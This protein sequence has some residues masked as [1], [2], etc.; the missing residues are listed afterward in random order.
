YLLDCQNVRIKGRGV[1]D[2][3][4]RALR[5]S[6]DNSSNGRMKLIRSLRATDCTVEGVI[7]RD[8]GTWSIHLIESSDLRFTNYKLISNTILDDPGFPWELNTDGFDPDNSSHVII[9]NGF[10]SCSDDAIAVKLGNGTRRDMSDIQFRDNVVWTVKSALKIGT[11]VYN[12]K[13]TDIVFENN[14]VVH[15]NLRIP[16]PHG[17]CRSRN[18]GLLQPR[19]DH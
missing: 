3:Q 16:H 15:A 11:E 7:L 19:R 6:T 1:I 2:G 10:I 18:C 13:M 8:A 12:Q 5:L 17:P 9:E 4:G 14:E